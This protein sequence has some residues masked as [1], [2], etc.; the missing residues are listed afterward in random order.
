MTAAAS[1]RRGQRDREPVRDLIARV[2]LAAVVER[3]AGPGRRQGG[4]WLF[5]CP[6]PQH[7]DRHPSFDVGVDRD[8][9]QR[10]RCRSACGWSGDA[11]D[12]IRWLDGCDTGE[13]VR[14]LRRLVGEPEPWTRTP[15]RSKP[16]TA[17]PPPLPTDTRHPPADVAAGLLA[18]YLT[19]RGWPAGVAERFG[20]EVVLDRWGRPRVRHP[21][22][23][24]GGDGATVVASWQDRALHP[25]QRPKWLAPSGRPLPPYNAA[26]LEPDDTAAVVV[27]EGPADTIT[28]AVAL[29]GVP[30]V[31]AIGVPGVA[32][33]QP[34]WAAMFDGLTVV[35]AVDNDPAGDQL[36]N[37]LRHDLAD[38][39]TRLVHVR[40]PGGVNDLCDLARTHGLDTVRRLLLR[41]LHPEPAAVAAAPTPPPA[42]PVD[43]Q[44]VTG[45]TPAGHTTQPGTGR[46]CTCRAPQAGPLADYQA[47]IEA[48]VRPVIPDVK[49][50]EPCRLHG[51]AGIHD[52]PTTPEVAA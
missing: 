4:R 40:L 15:R 11:L 41:A 50:P 47:W 36:R 28:A 42:R 51:E 9:V 30:G 13:A 49:P 19:G 23:V 3:Y 2:D 46:R 38:H 29:D 35:A 10:A 20:L 33:W 24:P 32:G 5:S 6:N 37:R 18:R 17:P 34:D 25:G 8:G 31:A 45:P 21:F 7:P 43:T 26:A 44:P 16:P 14:R 1:P 48:N 12:L 27:C 52:T 39:A 22:P